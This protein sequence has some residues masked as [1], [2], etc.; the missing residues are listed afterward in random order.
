MYI[1]E[2]TSDIRYVSGKDNVVADALSRIESIQ[3]PTTIGFAQV[4]RAQ[5]A[6]QLTQ[7]YHPNSTVQFKPMFIPNCDKPLHCEVSTKHSRP[8]IPIQFRKLAFETI[9]NISHP[10]IRSTRKMVA[11]KYFWPNLNKD[12]STWEKTCIQCQKSKVNRHT[13]SQFDNFPPGNRFEQIHVDIIGPLPT[14]QDGFRYCVTIIDLFT[15]WPEAFPV[16]DIT[17]ETVAKIIY[18]G[19]FVNTVVVKH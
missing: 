4:A 9:H 15:R 13:F 16:K 3:C 10:G 8:Y 18:T 14:S 1:S 12:V 7:Y 19:G 6:E 17:A 11:Q 2:F 5:E